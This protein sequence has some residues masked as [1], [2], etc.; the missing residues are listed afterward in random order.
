V[1]NQGVHHGRAIFFAVPLYFGG[2][3]LTLY[4]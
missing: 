3:N 4:Q 1:S 2:V